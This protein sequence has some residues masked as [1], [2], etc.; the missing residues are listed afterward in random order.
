MPLAPPP[1]LS[2]QL[3]TTLYILVITALT[4]CDHPAD[5]TR[6]SLF[7]PEG[8]IIAVIGPPESCSHS[9]AVAGGARRYCDRYP[10]INCLVVTPR[11]QHPES[12]RQAVNQ[13]LSAQPRGLCLHLEHTN[14]ADAI[15]DLLDPRD[16]VLVTMNRPAP[17]LRP[18]GHVGV[19]RAEAAELL[20]RSLPN[21]LPQAVDTLGR[22]R[23]ERSYVLV[24]ERTRDQDAADCYVRFAAAA[25][26]RPAFSLL[27]EVDTAA[28]GLPPRD[29]ITTLLEQFRTA[30]LVITLNPEPWLSLQPRLRLPAQNRF[31]T[32]SAAPRLW[33][34]LHAGEAAALVG[35]LDGELGYAAAELVVQG[36][37]AVPDATRQLAIRCEL[38]T[39]DSLADFVERYA[40]AAMLDIADLMPLPPP[41]PADPDQPTEP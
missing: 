24:H 13:A 33:P 2:R 40:A 9:K 30:E 1:K 41:A 14:A 34:R 12:L 6:R 28:E 19:A 25:P 21:L 17:Q 4:A 39:R 37:L 36:L 10:N 3:A 8:S 23:T 35:P 32:L 26:G 22:E 7:L 27:R 11:N 20:G 18:Y 31:A 15:A 29:A 16:F 38:V 5:T